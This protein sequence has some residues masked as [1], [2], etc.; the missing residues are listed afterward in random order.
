[1]KHLTNQVK[2]T[3]SKLTELGSNLPRKSYS[4]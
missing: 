4:K 1:L 2:L 3:I